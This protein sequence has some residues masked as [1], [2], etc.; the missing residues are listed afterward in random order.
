MGL[1][2]TINKKLFRIK[3][4]DHRKDL[5][6]VLSWVLSLVWILYQW[7]PIWVYQQ[8][9]ALKTSW[10]WHNRVWAH[11][12][13]SLLISNHFTALSKVAPIL[14]TL[15]IF[16]HNNNKIKFTNIVNSNYTMRKA[17]PNHTLFLEVI[18][19]KELQVMSH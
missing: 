16:N 2:L 11:F 1:H 12:Q 6:K 15:V 14:W 19:L 8:F 5:L 17:R 13:L 3:E 10:R 18:W 9:R 4:Q 7:I